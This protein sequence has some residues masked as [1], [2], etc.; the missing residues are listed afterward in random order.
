M[1]GYLPASVRPLLPWARQHV[2]AVAARYP[3]SIDDLWDEVVTALLRV[4]LHSEPWE[5]TQ[6]RAGT[7]EL[8]THYTKTAIHRA[9]WRYV[10]RRAEKRPRVLAI[11]DEVD[12]DLELAW[13]SAEEEV[14]AR[15]AV[16]LHQ[17]VAG[18]RAVTQSAPSATAC[19]L[20]L[21]DPPAA[22]RAVRASRRAGSG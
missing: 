4:T 22:R 12:L 13:A 11:G 9:C 15:E 16:F 8:H 5:R 7:Q 14:M 19:S 1:P 3:V 10:C 17:Q 20:V 21:Q 6:K 18:A 2:A